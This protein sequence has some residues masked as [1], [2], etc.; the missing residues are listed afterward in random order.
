MALLSER[1]H[2]IDTSEIRKVFDLA[3]KI[4][5]PVNLSIGQPDFPVPAPVQEAMIKAIKDN[6]TGYTQTTG[7]LELRE[8]ICRKWKYKNGFRVEPDNVIVSTGVAS[9]LFLLFQ[10]IIDPGDHILLTDPY[11]LIYPALVKYHGA[12][13]HLLSEDFGEKE[14]DKLKYFL[15]EKNIKLKAMIFS[16]PSNPTGKI[17]SEDQLRL[18][19]DFAR[20]RGILV[21]SDEIYEAFDYEK[22]FSS[23]AALYPEGTLTLNGFSKS[24]AMTGL[25]VGYMGAPQ[26]LSQIVQRMATLQQY[27]MVCAPQ[28]MQWAAI[29]ALDTP[30]LQELKQMKARRDLVVSKLAGKT[31]FPF[32]DGAFYAYPQINE[33]SKTF[34]E[35]AI[36][37]RLLVVPGYIFSQQ[38]NHIRISYAQKVEILEEGLDI[39]LK[40][41]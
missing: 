32:P 41:L 20:N 16:T 6:K 40:L 11:F 12:Q 28:P 23:T 26:E 22:K 2:H 13:M 8:A 34:I 33:D 5:N 38:S 24:H 7:L 31:E 9:I 39:F 17:L 36:Q 35:K 1:I 15:T 18:L 10:T 30:I 25:R 14:L 19:T 37:N 4:K 21:I 3:A 29:T 27:S